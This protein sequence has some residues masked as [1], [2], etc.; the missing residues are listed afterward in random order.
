MGGGGITEVGA[1]RYE[2]WTGALLLSQGGALVDKLWIY[3]YTK[4]QIK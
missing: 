4:I 1:Y 2:R 3:F